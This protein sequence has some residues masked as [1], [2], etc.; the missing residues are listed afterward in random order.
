MFLYLCSVLFSGYRQLNGNLV[1]GQNNSKHR[2]C[3][4]Y[5]KRTIDL[6]S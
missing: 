5:R 1:D 4:K 2:Y 6:S 3:V